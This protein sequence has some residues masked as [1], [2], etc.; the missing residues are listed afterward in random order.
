MLIVGAGGFAAESLEILIQLNYSKEV[1]FF[2]NTPDVKTKLFDR[3]TILKTE[4]SVRDLFNTGQSDFILGVGG[5]SARSKLFDLMV[6]WG[7]NPYAL[8]S[9]LAIIGK[10][11]NMID[12]GCNIMTN[13]VITSNVSVQK[14][15][16]INLNTTIGHDTVIGEF[17]DICPG[18]N[19][20][21][22]CSIG[23]NTFVG[24]GSILL[25]KIKIGKNVVIAAGS[26]VTKDVPDSVMIA[27]N[28]AVIKKQL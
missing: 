9:P 16:L 6:S 1:F 12:P 22:N 20:S 7:G 10:C 11:S 3:Y 8:I 2:D 28:P 19:I 15:V 21:G 4:A 27:G 25:P 23:S 26:V 14:G 18:V 13:V 5:S 17:V 24:T